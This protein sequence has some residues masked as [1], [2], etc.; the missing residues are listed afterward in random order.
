MGQFLLVEFRHLQLG[1]ESHIR[2]C[3]PVDIRLHGSQVLIRFHEGRIRLGSEIV[4]HI[5]VSTTY[6]PKYP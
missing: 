6:Q 1:A 3:F 4:R 2:I 5:I